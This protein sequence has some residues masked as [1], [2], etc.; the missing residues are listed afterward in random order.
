VNPILNRVDS[1]EAGR[2]G[3]TNAVKMTEP[4]RMEFQDVRETIGI[5]FIRF[6]SIKL[7]NN[8]YAFH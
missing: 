6:V 5:F 8:R 1:H 4:R 2:H 7:K 3:T